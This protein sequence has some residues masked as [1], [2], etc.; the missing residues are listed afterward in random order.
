MVNKRTLAMYSLGHLLVDA[1]CITG[2][3]MIIGRESLSLES[4]VSYIFLYNIVAFAGQMVIGFFCD[5][6]QRP[7]EF[8]LIGMVLVALGSMFMAVPILAAVLLAVGNGFYHVGGG[9]I[10]FYIT[11]NR[12]SGPGIFVAPGAIGV[13]IGTVMTKTMNNVFILLALLIIIGLLIFKDSFDRNI[14]YEREYPE[15]DSGFILFMFALLF[16]ICIRA[17]IGGSLVFP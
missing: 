10:S 16:V 4:M 3:L 5:E 7:K 12:A 6:S 8:A 13:L 15:I 2:V 9:L 14:V 11:P 17:M 1:V